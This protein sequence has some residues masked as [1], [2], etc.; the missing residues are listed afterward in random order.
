[1]DS[2]NLNGYALDQTTRGREAMKL[3]AGTILRGTVVEIKKGRLMTRV[4]VDISG[5]DIV[6][7]MVTEAA[8]KELGAKV[9]EELE[10]LTGDLAAR[11]LH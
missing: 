2:A 1:M 3:S 9:G 7:V 6:T 11:G 5:D 4:K 10:V 8:L